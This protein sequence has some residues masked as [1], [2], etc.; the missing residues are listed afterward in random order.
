MFNEEPTIDIIVFD[1]H[2]PITPQH[3]LIPNRDGLIY[4]QDVYFLG[5]PYGFFTES[6]DQ[7]NEYPFPFVKKGIVSAFT[8]DK[9][10]ID[11]H[12][13][14]GFSGG[15]IVFYPENDKK[16]HVTGIISGYFRDTKSTDELTLSINE[17]S[18]LFIGYDIS[19][20]INAINN[21]KKFQI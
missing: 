1:I 5:F 10:F 11:G 4:S 13:N 12:N 21:D 6:G 9:I 7:N 3:E 17:N 20:A 2:Q 15:P 19:H 8:S 16:L 14:K 18:G